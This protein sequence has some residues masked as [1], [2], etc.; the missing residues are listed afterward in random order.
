[1]HW[2]LSSSLHL[3]I[4][5]VAGIVVGGGVVAAV[6][7]RVRTSG[8]LDMTGDDDLLLGMLVLAGF[9]LGAFLTYALV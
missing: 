6:L 3:I 7:T 4:S 5:L 2:M 8:N 9:V 1:M